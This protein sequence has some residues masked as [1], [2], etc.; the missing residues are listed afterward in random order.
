[1]L[2]KDQL[3]QE[4]MDQ[5]GLQDFG[6]ED[7]QQPLERLIAALNTQAKLNDF[8][9][10]RAQFTINAGLT[11]RLKIQQY[12]CEHPEVRDEVVERPVF[13]VGLPRTG[14]TALHHML[15][16]DSSNHTL[17]LWEAQ[18]PIPPPQTATYTTDSR[19]AKQ[20]QGVEMTETFL[21]GFLQTHLIDAEEP[22][23][24]Y[25]LLNRNFMSVEYS[26]MFHIP[27]YANWLYE[28]LPDSDCYAY[29]KVQ[30]Q[31]LQ[32]QRPGCWVLKAPFHQLGLR[33][34]LAQYPDAIIVQTHRAPMSFVASGCSFSELLRK[35]GSDDIDKKVIGRD[36]MD[37]LSVYTRTFEADRAVLEVQFPG[38]FMDMNHDAFVADPWPTIDEIY[39]LRGAPLSKTGRAGMSDWLD[40][41]PKGKHGKHVYSLEEY[42]ITRAEIETLFGDYVERYNLTMD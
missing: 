14:T 13:I 2:D 15:N 20:R 8:G 1:V 23:E 30:L 42:G 7:F 9:S 6:E 16:Q 12:L 26:A 38:Q 19:I 4:A 32:S 40:A 29:H 10:F 3:L 27:S 17:R 22:D 28:T 35:S 5:T 39:R 41:N 31:L 33:G 18:N 37:M 11:N 34:I 24:C 36:W 25:M 21:P